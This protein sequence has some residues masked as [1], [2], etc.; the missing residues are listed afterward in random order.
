MPFP[1]TPD[2]A[3]N[4]SII[5]S[6]LAPS[7]LRDVTVTG[8]RSGIHAGRIEPLPDGAGTEFVPSRAFEPG[9]RVAVSAQLSSPEAGTASGAPGSTRLRFSFGVAVVGPWGSG[10]PQDVPSASAARGGGPTKH[11]H[12]RP[13]LEPTDVSVT[14][15]P[16]T[17]S[18]DIFI[19]PDH[20]SQMGPM[21]LNPEG[22]IVW[23]RPVPSGDKASNFAVQ[24]YHGHPVLTYWQ[25]RDSGKD[26]V[27]VIVNRHYKTTAVVHPVGNGYGADLHD[28]QIIHGKAFLITV[29]PARADLSSVGGPKSGYVWDNIIQEVDIATGKLLWQWNS[30]GHIPLN[31][32]HKPPQGDYYDFVHLNSIQPLPDGSLLVSSR[33]TWSVYKISVK[34]GQIL[35]TLGGKYNQFNRGTGVGWA[36]QHDV[37]RSGN[38]LTMFDDGAA[39]QVEQESSAKVISVNAAAKTATLVHRYYHNPPLVASAQGSAQ[40]L[41]NGDM[42]V[43]WGTEPD[44]SEVNSSGHQIFNG[45]F[46]LGETS[47]RAF[48]FPWSGQPLSRPAMAVAPRG[49]GQV[50]VWA[51]WDGATDVA[52]WRVIGGRSANRLNWLDKKHYFSF[53]T[54]ITLHNQPPYFAVQALG[55]QKQVLGTSSAHALPKHVSIF[56]STAFVPRAGDGAVP[57]GCFT[58]SSCKVT[59]KVTSGSSVLAQSGP[60]RVSSDRG[61]FASFQLSSQGTRELDQAPQHG[62]PVE[63]SV[64]DVSGVSA[65]SQVN[66]IPFS[67]Q[68]SGPTRSLDESPTI[69]LVG[70]T[71][72]ASGD[73]VAVLAACYA[74]HP[75][76][77]DGRI[78]AAGKRI[79]RLRSG[80]LGIDELGFLY[81][82]LNR[83]GQ[84]ML[85]HATG[86][87][88]PAK[89][90]LTSGRHTA[91]GHVA[92]ARYS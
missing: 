91:T 42:F 74:G 33:N 83:R 11:F 43:G 88:L 5:F 24:T 20:A 63:V 27:D 35:W 77:V 49:D 54:E 39:P 3:P 84:S 70:T 18:G 8:S 81:V 38:T 48:R 64:R 44:F 65:T 57:V 80:H 21:I 73:Q 51:S 61:G 52:A 56:G 4:S 79:G 29:V 89:V 46:P 87:Q 10:P 58:G 37:R 41:P 75:C 85:S 47:Y 71:E 26:G 76:H 1:G 40:A 53:E 7:A 30:Y 15:D 32:S 82:K 2:A 66:L 19:S 68:G 59:V 31:A 72:F 16:D 12:S 34:T 6:S 55:S 50:N 69:Q 13:D 36:W 17:T 67:V 60:Q 62:L 22:Q 25:G 23:F 78:T 92:L 14:S 86:N 28:F 45:T 9:E 90:T